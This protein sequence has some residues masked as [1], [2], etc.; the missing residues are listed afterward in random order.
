M[1]WPVSLIGRNLAYGM[2]P[3][4]TA[5]AD[6]GVTYGLKLTAV[7]GFYLVLINLVLGVGISFLLVPYEFPVGV[8]SGR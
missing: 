6:A 8:R 2:D 7:V 5:L 4:N 1:V 3:L